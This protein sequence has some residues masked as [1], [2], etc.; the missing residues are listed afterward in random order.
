MLWGGR[1]QRDGTSTLLGPS[2]ARS[3][4]LSHPTLRLR[5]RLSLAMRMSSSRTRTRFGVVSKNR[6]VRSMAR[7][8]GRHARLV[9]I[10]ATF[11][12]KHLY[13]LRSTFQ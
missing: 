2:L 13:L 11:T 5:G 4:L 10:E 7:F 6:D 12:R 9:A 8:M 1:I 3:L